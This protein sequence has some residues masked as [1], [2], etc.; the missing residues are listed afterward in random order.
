MKNK[1][2]II[3]TDYYSLYPEVFEL[4]KARA[5]QVIAVMKDTF[6]RHGIPT[7][8]VSDNG[9]QYKSYLFRKFAKE[10]DFQHNTSSP[11]YPQSNGL[12]EASVKTV[13]NMMKKCIE[14]N[15]DIVQGLLTIRN[16]PLPCGSSP[17]QLLMNRQLNDNLPRLP[18]K[19]DTDKP[20]Q[21]NLMA[22][23]TAQKKQHDK[24]IFH[25]LPADAFRAGQRVA[26][27]DPATKLWTDRGQIVKEVAPRSFE[28]KVDGKNTLR[29]NQRQLR[30]LYSTTS[31]REE[32][33]AEEEHNEPTQQEDQSPYNSDSD[34]DSSTSTIP[35]DE[36]VEAYEQ[37]VASL[38]RSK[39]SVHFRAPTDYEDL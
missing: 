14:S 27:Q 21:R 37:H 8:L 1:I 25:N 29:R 39:R 18:A 23:R 28:V 4:K 9:S 12:A 16:T 31:T 32:A 20:A 34:S 22:E 13:K 6:A 26:L 5:P 15:K 35:Y 38:P 36:D 30:K 2:Y 10:W 19:M 3:I 11:R 33:R 24:K 17:A 7:E